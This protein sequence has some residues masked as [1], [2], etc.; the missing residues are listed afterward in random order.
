M[1]GEVLLRRVMQWVGCMDVR[2]YQG[3]LCISALVISLVGY[4]LVTRPIWKSITEARELSAGILEYTSR[5]EELVRQLHQLELKGRS[6]KVAVDTGRVPTPSSVML[7]RIHS[8]AA[9]AGVLITEF[10]NAGAAATEVSGDEIGIRFSAQGTFA[11]TRRFAEL[12]SN[13]EQGFVV[14][15]MVI[16]NV[17]WPD[18]TGELRVHVGGIGRRSVEESF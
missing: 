1:K 16:E 15:E 3:V 7:D 9:Q 13:H 2:L 4:V 5:K 6:R 12:L 10:T 14:G 18:F 17:R 8:H 11:Q